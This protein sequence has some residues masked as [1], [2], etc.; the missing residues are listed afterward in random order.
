M[1]KR[2][3]EFFADIAARLDDMR[4]VPTGVLSNLVTRNGACM[5]L[6][7]GPDEPEWAGHDATNR[8]IAAQI[9]AGCSVLDAC[10]ELEFRTAGLTTLGV[11]GALS[12]DDRRTAYLAW[13]Q[14]RDEQQDG[15]RA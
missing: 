6:A 5:S 14:R 7:A 2:E 15:G 13:F 9:C 10:L 3:D 1:N 12:E 4:S 11:W 8:E